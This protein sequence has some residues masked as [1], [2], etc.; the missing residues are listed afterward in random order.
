MLSII[1]VTSTQ[2]VRTCPIASTANAMLVLK[3]MVY[4]V[5]I[6]MSVKIQQYV[7]STA[8]AIILLEVLIVSV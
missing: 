7:M 8:S 2:H 3:E 1:P 5:K 6:L 4:P